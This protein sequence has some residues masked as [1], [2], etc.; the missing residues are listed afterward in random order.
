[1]TKLRN[2]LAYEAVGLSQKPSLEWSCSVNS[3]KIKDR[4]KST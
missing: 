1:M 2:R 3:R 4:N